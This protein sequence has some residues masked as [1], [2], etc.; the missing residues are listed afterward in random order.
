[1]KNWIHDNDR[2]IILNSKVKLYRNL[3]NLSFPDK[4]NSIVAIEKSR[5]IYDALVKEIE[6][7]DFKLHEIWNGE[8]EFYNEYIEK[9]LGSKDALKNP[10]KVS[11]IINNNETINILMNNSNHIEIECVTAGFNIQDAFE[12]AMRLDNKIEENF[13]YAYDDELG[14]LT[15]S[16]DILG[17]AMKVSVIMNLPALKMSEEIKNISKSLEEEGFKIISIYKDDN[18]SLGNMY[19]IINKTTL[20]ISEEDMVNNL[21]KAVLRIMNKEMEL[22]E[23]MMSKCRVEIE[24]KVF[25]AYAILKNA[26]IL[27]F[28]EAIEL[29]SN[30]R[31]G[32][33]LSLLDVEKSK[34]NQLQV[35]IGDR[36][37]QNYFSTQLDLKEIK[38]KRADLVKKILV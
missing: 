20:G 14:Y 27:D 10:D 26:R 21:E 7:N 19:E 11:V 23:I 24:D 5:S 2:G 3:K 32:C 18:K 12:E 28:K 4:L 29:L 1:M 6:D 8:K 33:E 22:R 13:C 38:Y 35:I 31:L 25:R 37:L 30:V 36:Y 16:L 15:S 34:I 17:T 9:E